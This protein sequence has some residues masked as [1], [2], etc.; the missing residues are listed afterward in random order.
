MIRTGIRVGWTRIP[1]SKAE[2]VLKSTGS[3]QMDKKQELMLHKRISSISDDD[4]D[5][6]CHAFLQLISFF[7]RKLSICLGYLPVKYRICLS[8]FESV[9]KRCREAPNGPCRNDRVSD[10]RVRMW[11]Q[12]SSISSRSS[13]T[14]WIVWI[15]Q[16]QFNW[17]SQDA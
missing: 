15:S 6:G 12:R 2:T 9:T 16:D 17:M 13:P 10:F 1:L 14:I 5:D 11:K 7:K 8:P 4:P 3:R